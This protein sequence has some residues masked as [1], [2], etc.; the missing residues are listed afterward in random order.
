[1]FFQY[2]QNNSYGTF[3]YDEEAGIGP[4]VIVEADDAVGADWR[5]ERIGLYFDG[6]GDCP[7]CGNR[8]SSAHLAW[9]AATPGD[10]VPSIYGEPVAENYVQAPK[11]SSVKGIRAEHK[12]ELF[13]HYIEGD[14]I[15]GWSAKP[16][17]G[18]RREPG[19]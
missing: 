3:D 8:W 18:E 19:D 13:I 5:A 15:E 4:Y 2:T 11:D 9:W 10:R 7:C 16:N 14:R 12:Y 6:E 1:M 17:T